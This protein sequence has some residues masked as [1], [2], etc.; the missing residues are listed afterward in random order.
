MNWTWVVREDQE[1]LQGFGPEQ[2]EGSNYVPM[3]QDSEKL[4]KVLGEWNGETEV[5]KL[6]KAKRFEQFIASW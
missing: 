4:G 5:R 1:W 2:L 6:N 3:R